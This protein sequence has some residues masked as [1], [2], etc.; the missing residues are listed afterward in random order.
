M[1]LKISNDLPKTL[2]ETFNDKKSLFFRKGSVI[3][4]ENEPAAG[5]YF[6]K[7]GKVKIVKY[8][9]VFFVFNHIRE[10][11]FTI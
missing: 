3:F 2:I 9:L 11:F 6:I 5:V 1:M 10:H 4:L 7:D 8:L